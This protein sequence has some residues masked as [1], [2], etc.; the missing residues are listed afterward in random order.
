MNDAVD[1][2]SEK[3]VEALVLAH[4]T[5]GLKLSLYLSAARKIH[6]GFCV[7]VYDHGRIRCRICGANL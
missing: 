4:G 1:R 2:P 3:L 6:E 7:G 5:T